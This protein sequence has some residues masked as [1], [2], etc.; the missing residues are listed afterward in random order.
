MSAFAEC[1]RRIYA[2]LEDL[3]REHPGLPTSWQ[4][5]TLT[6]FSGVEYDACPW[7]ALSALRDAELA[8]ALIDGIREVCR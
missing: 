1:H 2:A 5:H 4:V 3:E 6:P 7:M 8:A